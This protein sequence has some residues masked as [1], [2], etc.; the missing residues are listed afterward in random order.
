MIVCIV[1]QGN[2]YRFCQQRHLKR[3]DQ[4][5]DLRTHTIL[6]SDQPKVRIT[7]LAHFSVKN[8]ILS[9]SLMKTDLMPTFFTLLTALSD[10]IA[11]R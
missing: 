6:I 10:F 2:I 8:G 11:I 5:H 1:S 4:G 9:Q 7:G 3:P